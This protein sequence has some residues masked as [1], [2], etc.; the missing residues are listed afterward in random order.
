MGELSGSLSIHHKWT[1][2]ASFELHLNGAIHTLTPER[3]RRV[4]EF[5]N[6]GIRECERSAAYWSQKCAACKS[7]PTPS[8]T[9]EEARNE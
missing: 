3:A 1:G 2:P 4:V 5:L 6:D 7:S 9:P 8:T